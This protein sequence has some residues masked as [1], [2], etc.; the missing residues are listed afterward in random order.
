MLLVLEGRTDWH[1]SLEDKKESCHLLVLLKHL[2]K[3][4]ELEMGPC[5]VP[6]HTRGTS[7]CDGIPVS[8]WKPQIIK[9]ME[10]KR[11][12]T[13]TES[14]LIV[15]SLWLILSCVLSHLITSI[16]PTNNEEAKKPL[17]IQ[18][19][20]REMHLLTT[21]SPTWENLKLIIS[22]V[23]YQSPFYF[24]PILFKGVF[25]PKKR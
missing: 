12:L 1:E 5:A 4:G 24:I 3:R 18:E 23:D 2:S 16:H 14:P 13:C 9:N 21:V 22:P 25:S 11:R 19:S 7:M 20:M 15:S 17:S 6:L 10:E 8:P